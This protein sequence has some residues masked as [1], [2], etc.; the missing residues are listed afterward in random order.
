MKSE[1]NPNGFSVFRPLVKA[2]GSVVSTA[3]K[4]LQ[5]RTEIRWQRSYLLTQAQPEN[6]V[7]QS[8]PSEGI[9]LF[10]L[11]GLQ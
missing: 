3:D 9:D 7:G 11:F 6:T 4:S 10:T 1:G 2:R 5:L 8:V